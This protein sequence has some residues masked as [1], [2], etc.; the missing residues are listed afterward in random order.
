MRVKLSIVGLILCAVSAYSQA[1]KESASIQAS[2]P[3]IDAGV[4]LEI[5]MLGANEKRGGTEWI[6]A[7]IKRFSSTN[8]HYKIAML[9]IDEPKR[10]YVPIENIP[11]LPRNVF[12]IS[13][14][15]GYEPMYLAARDEIVPI[16]EFLP[17]PDFKKEDFYEPLWDPITYDGK[18]WGVPWCSDPRMII[19]DWRLFEEAGFSEMPRTWEELLEVAGRLTKDT[20]GDGEIDQWGFRIDNVDEVD[21]WMITMVLQKG[22]K[23]FSDLGLDA[24]DPALREAIKTVQRFIASGYTKIYPYQAK[25]NERFAMQFEDVWSINSEPGAPEQFHDRQPDFRLMPLPTDGEDVQLNYS[26]LY[27]TIRRSTPEQE[28]A[29]WELVKWLTRRDVTMPT[30][31]GGY[32]CRKDFVER[33]D[34]KASRTKS[35]PNLELAYQLNGKLKNYGPKN[36]QGLFAGWQVLFE[37]NIDLAIQQGTDIDAALNKG[38]KEAAALI[39]IMPEPRSNAYALYK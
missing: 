11:A 17:D 28:A 24:T 3:S 8:P 39:K 22:G 26:T 4:S 14:L 38:S 36:I 23:L 19:C 13:S 9:N 33:E 7:E 37:K 35:F 15:M 20:D 30:F 25:P 12:G 32:P 1:P 5:G 16:E 6:T 34:F 2:E 29:S 18:T 10:W 31:W 27:L 21:F